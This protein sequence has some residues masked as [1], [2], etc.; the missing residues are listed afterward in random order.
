[1]PYP[2]LLR[3]SAGQLNAYALKRS[4]QQARAIHA[5]PAGA[6]PAVG[7]TCIRTCRTD[8]LGRLAVSYANPTP[9]ITSPLN[10]F[11]LRGTGRKQSQQKHG[12]QHMLSE[13]AVSVCCLDH[14]ANIRALSFLLKATPPQILYFISL[15]NKGEPHRQKQGD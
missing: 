2:Y 13:K 11:L 14:E 7:R 4:K 8:D 1:M 9:S 15:G 10:S 3:S 6:T 12:Q 5:A